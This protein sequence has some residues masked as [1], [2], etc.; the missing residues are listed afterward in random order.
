MCTTNTIKSTL[1]GQSHIIY[2]EFNFKSHNCG[3]LSVL[4]IYRIDRLTQ[5]ILVQLFKL[6]QPHNGK[7]PIKMIISSF[8][9][10]CD[11]LGIL[12]ELDEN[13]QLLI[14]CCVNVWPA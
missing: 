13:K 8:N 9:S 3:H 5:P 4:L 7:S 12:N 10:E 2:K 6:T 1:T 14:Q 11:L